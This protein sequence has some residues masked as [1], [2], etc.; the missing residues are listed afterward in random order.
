MGNADVEER[1]VVRFTPPVSYQRYEAVCKLLKQD[2]TVTKVVDFGCSTG[3]LFRHLKQLDHLTHYAAVDISYSCLEE[4]YQHAKP[5][6]WDC[7]YR[8]SRALTV[9]FFQGSVADG[10]SRLLGFH[11]V[12]C[13]ELVEHLHSEDLQKM[14]ET[15]FGFIQPKIAV[16]TTPNRDFN[17][18][19]PDLEGM[20]HWD[21]KFEWSRAEF[22]KWCADIVERYPSYEVHYTGVGKTEEEKFEGVGYCTQIAIFRRIC[23]ADDSA[24]EGSTTHESTPA[25]GSTPSEESAPQDSAPRESAPGESAPQDSEPQETALHGPYELVFTGKYPGRDEA[26]HPSGGG[27]SHPCEGETSHSGE[28]ETSHT[29]EDEAAHSGEDETSHPYEDEASHPGEE[30]TSHP[31]GGDTSHHVKD[32]T[33]H[34]VKDETSHLGGDE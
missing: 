18:V 23:T 24:P 27:S 6:A 31:G 5:L 20:R 17:V 12:V 4:A 13:I 14:P 28:D 8:R 26:S 3:R 15:I 32:V 2:P 19:F 9:Q 30:Q 25:E 29:D 1:N 34:F 11:A 33:G 22:E 21:H 16:I 10:D 7:I